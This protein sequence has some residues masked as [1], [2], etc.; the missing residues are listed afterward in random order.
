MS[1]S[2]QMLA[3][4]YEMEDAIKQGKFALF[5]Q[6]DLFLT[7]VVGVLNDQAAILKRTMLETPGQ[8]LP[9]RQPDVITRG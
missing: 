1:R 6:D 2:D 3:I 7:Q 4:F 8:T 5:V 9:A